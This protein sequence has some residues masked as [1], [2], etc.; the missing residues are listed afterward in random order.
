MQRCVHISL[1]RLYAPYG[2]AMKFVG[3]DRPPAA[4][5]REQPTPLLPERCEPSVLSFAERKR[6]ALHEAAHAVAART[7]GLVVKFA[8]I[9][10]TADIVIDAALGSVRYEAA[11][12]AWEHAVV[13]L[14]GPSA[15]VVFYSGQRIAGADDDLA[16]AHQYARQ[17]DPKNT[18]RVIAQAWRAAV[19][20]VRDNCTVISCLAVVLERK[21]KLSGAAI[22]SIIGSISISGN[23]RPGPSRP[24]GGE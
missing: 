18:D 23:A 8:R 12:T 16:H 17:V 11:G 1:A 14:A 20:L 9:G 15:D 19:K 21:G 5:K 10:T 6:I 13:A 4:A 3:D 2:A 24:R 7:Y 22:D